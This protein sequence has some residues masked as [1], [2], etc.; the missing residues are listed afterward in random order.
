M[1]TAIQQYQLEE[2]DFA[3]GRNWFCVLYPALCLSGAQ[4]DYPTKAVNA[5]VF[6]RY[7]VRWAVK[8]AVMQIINKK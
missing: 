6:G 3:R 7:E 1:G 2:K 8:D 4:S 5:L